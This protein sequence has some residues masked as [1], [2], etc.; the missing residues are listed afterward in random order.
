ML[1]LLLMQEVK[2]LFDYFDK[3]G[4]GS[5]NIDEFII[6]FRVRNMLFSYLSSPHLHTLHTLVLITIYIYF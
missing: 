1:L 2:E 6:A 3:D 4:E 5:I